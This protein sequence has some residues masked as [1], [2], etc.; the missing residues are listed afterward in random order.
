MVTSD[1]L[2]LHKKGVGMR[3]TISMSVAEGAQSSCPAVGKTSLSPRAIVGPGRIA[4]RR[5]DSGT[6]DHLSWVGSCVMDLGILLIA[7]TT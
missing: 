7:G 3:H 6:M 2:G 1:V 5:R 4:L